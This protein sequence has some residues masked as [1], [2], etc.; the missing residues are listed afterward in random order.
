MPYGGDMDT[1]QASS[2]IPVDGLRT[3]AGSVAR[4]AFDLAD[5]DRSGWVVPL[6]V[7]G[8]S[9]TPHFGDQQQA[10]RTGQLLP[11]PYSRRAVAA[12]AADRLMLVPG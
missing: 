4:Y 6:G 3:A 11:A 5:W 8:E 7:S 12:A 9:G 1:V 10:W 2:Y